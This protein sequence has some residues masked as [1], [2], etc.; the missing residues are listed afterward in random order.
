M[1][2]NLREEKKQKCLDKKE[3]QGRKR[4]ERERER[5]TDR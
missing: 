1:A 5:Q 2:I 4:E 3:E